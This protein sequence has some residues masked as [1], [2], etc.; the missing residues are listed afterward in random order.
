[1]SSGPIVQVEEKRVKESKDVTKDSLELSSKDSLELSTCQHTNIMQTLEDPEDPSDLTQDTQ[2]TS[3]PGQSPQQRHDELIALANSSSQSEN[4]L[5][6]GLVVTPVEEVL[7]TGD[8]SDIFNMTDIAGII[9]PSNA[10]IKNLEDQV[11][12][13]TKSLND[14][15]S[16]NEVHK[17]D[18]A[19]L[20][21][22]VEFLRNK[23]D[24]AEKEVKHKKAEMA[25]LENALKKA[26]EEERKGKADKDIAAL[27]A[28]VA[29]VTAERDRLRGQAE[30]NAKLSEMM[31]RN[32]NEANV[33]MDRMMKET[34][35]KD[36]S[37]ESSHPQEDEREPLQ[38]LQHQ[39]VSEFGR[40][41]QMMLQPS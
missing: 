40:R 19:R 35:C 37:C 8:N 39:Y 23:L 24:D 30:A 34:I 4:L 36:K 7:R 31:E 14:A 16:L 9:N 29:K 26:V 2:P 41:L 28:K 6:P 3:T 11:S 1:M 21:R 5:T 32:L 13:R 15:L 25:K 22:E 38:V 10:I 12:T 27:Q 33:K 18:K 20:E 17:T